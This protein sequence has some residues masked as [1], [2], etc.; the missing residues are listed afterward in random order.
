LAHGVMVAVVAV[1]V[2]AGAVVAGCGHRGAQPP[3]AAIAMACGHEATDAV[4][5]QIGEPLV[6]PVVPAWRQGAY[7]CRYRYADGD[8]DVVMRHAGSA[9]IAAQQAH[10]WATSRGIATPLGL[11]TSSYAT[12]DGSVVVAKASMALLVDVT[13]APPRMGRPPIPR[14][15]VAQVVAETILHCW[16]GS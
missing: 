3:P 2:V 7:R 16:T 1:A 10:D 11:G 6:A 9:T 8:V 15:D 13:A 12:T 14:A 5:A 4:A